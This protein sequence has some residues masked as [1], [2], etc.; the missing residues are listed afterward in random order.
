VSNYFTTV[1]STANASDTAG[2]AQSAAANLGTVYQTISTYSGNTFGASAT[3][4]VSTTPASG[5]YWAASLSQGSGQI[6]NSTDIIADTSGTD[7]SSTAFF[8]ALNST[9]T[10]ETVI[11]G[12]WSL[13]F[14]AVGGSAT[15][16]TLTWTPT[17]VPLPAAV[18]LLGS[19]LLGLAG[20]SRRRLAVSSAGAG[21]FSAA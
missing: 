15:S 4:S 2:Q 20:V 19:A 7:T 11:S 5:L 13:V 16:A 1:T 14:N 10:V 8:K 18:W 21:Q 9:G 3:G 12:V 6:N 17:A